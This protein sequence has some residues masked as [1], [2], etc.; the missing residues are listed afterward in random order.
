MTKLLNKPLKSFSLYALLILLCSIPAYYFLLNAI[1]VKELDDHNRGKLLRVEKVL[2][3]SKVEGEAFE[4]MVEHWEKLDP[5]MRLVVLDQPEKPS[6]KYYTV[7]RRDPYNNEMESFR[8]LKRIVEVDGA[9]IQLTVQSDMEG[10]D[11]MV[12][13]IVGVTLLFIGVLLLGFTLLNRRISRK[14]WKPFYDTIE[15]L[16]EFSLMRE[17]GL[18]FTE[19]DIVEFA[20]LN[21]G[22][23]RLIQKNISVYRKQREF[24][25][26]ASHELQTPVALIKSKLDVLLQ[27]GELSEK[28]LELVSKLHP[29]LS[30]L[31]RLNKNL[32]LLAKLENQQFSEMEP[33]NVP[34]LLSETIEMFE[35][36]AQEKEQIISSETEPFMLKANRD[37]FEALLGNLFSNAIR[38]SETG[39]AIQVVLKNG[40]LWVRNPGT[41]SL[42]GHSLFDRFGRSS[43]ESGNVGLGLAIVKEIC[44]QNHW[45]IT[46]AF[47]EKTH[48]F[49]VDFR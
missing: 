48:Q 8:V 13:I 36:Y 49:Q 10:A 2:K 21:A 46:Y 20:E 7:E 18:N 3:E 42:S 22:L 5:N 23:E 9:S 17:E 47:E 11:E 19:T 24:I 45:K 31:S 30:R 32:L 38:Y 33:V 28:Q 25:E 34:E 4:L 40:T 43:E 44:D 41:R 27:S 37:L 14:S 26:N 29:P 12:V 6:E 16:K 1:T 39:S 35:D 15:K